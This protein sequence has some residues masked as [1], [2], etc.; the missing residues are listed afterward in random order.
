MVPDQDI[1]RGGCYI[2]GQFGSVDGRVET[3]MRMVNKTLAGVLDDRRRTDVRRMGV[4]EELWELDRR[5]TDE[6]RKTTGD[7]R[8]T[9]DGR[10]PDAGIGIPSGAEPG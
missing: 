10:L 6:G 5:T 2:D 8:R 1:Q 7:G 3:Q 9:T 4:S